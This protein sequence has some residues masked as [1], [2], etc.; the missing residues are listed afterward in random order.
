MKNKLLKLAYIRKRDRKSLLFVICILLL[1]SFSDEIILNIKSSE[2]ADP[3]KENIQIS[4]VAISTEKST[5]SERPTRALDTLRQDE[6]ESKKKSNSSDTMMHKDSTGLKIEKIPS[7]ISKPLLVQKID[8]NKP[9]IDYITSLGVPPKVAYTWQKYTNAGGKIYNTEDLAKVYGMTDDLIAK[10]DEHIIF[11]QKLKFNKKEKFISVFINQAS[12][13][14]FSKIS[15]IGPTLSERIVKFRDKL[16]GFHSISQLKEVYGIDAVIIDENASS[17]LIEKPVNKININTCDEEQ[18]GMHIYCSYRVAKAIINYRKQHGNFTG[19]GD[20]RE[21][22]IVDE[23]WI[24]K[25]S[26]YLE[27]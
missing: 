3:E 10:I 26:P 15:G 6:P 21:L 25:I 27:Y 22:R 17:F 9:S 12:A 8:P 13:Y 11:P 5:I 19:P 1:S 20:L 24:D 4:T 18:L 2:R 16:G 14:E 7:K 23:N